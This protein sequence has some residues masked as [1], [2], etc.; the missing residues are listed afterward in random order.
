MAFSIKTWLDRVSEY[1][2]R[3]TITDAA[4]PSQIQTVFLARHEGEITE[5]G[6]PLNAANLNDL[7]QRIASAD[8][9]QT[10]A[11]PTANPTAEA[12]ATLNKITIN[13]TVYSIEGGGITQETQTITLLASNWTADNTITVNVSGVT[14]D[15]V[16]EL[17]GLL[18]TSAA[19]IEN[20][21]ALQACN[22]ME[23]GQASGTITLYAE[24]VPEIDL[25][26]R[27]VVRA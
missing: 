5:A 16:Q 14:T 24:N 6:T 13:G 27:V 9:A 10:A 25:Q 15:S 17:K 20:N 2:T 12:T 22:I 3:R 4:D 19:N 1:P 23:A 26:M 7:E 18:A 11:N 21:K 8:A